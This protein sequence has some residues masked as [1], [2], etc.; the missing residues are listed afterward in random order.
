MSIIQNRFSQPTVPITC[1]NPLQAVLGTAVT[2]PNKAKEAALPEQPQPRKAHTHL[3]CVS[4]TS[5]C[6][7]F[8]SK[9]LKSFVHSLDLLW[10]MLQLL[11]FKF[12]ALSTKSD[13]V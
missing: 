12:E 4:L 1:L 10:L 5:C 6:L 3:K 7:T 8:K 2:D 11:P 13:N 9:M